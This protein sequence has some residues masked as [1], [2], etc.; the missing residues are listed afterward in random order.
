MCIHY[1]VCVYVYVWGGMCVCIRVSV[2]LALSLGEPRLKH[3]LFLPHPA[4][5]T[6]LQ[7][8]VPSLY[9]LELT[10]KTVKSLREHWGKEGRKEGRFTGLVYE[11]LVSLLDL[12]SLIPS[13]S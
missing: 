8:W 13:L 3:P 9:S 10:L 1:N 4:H 5:P 2:L 11:A 6:I 7:Q 12:C